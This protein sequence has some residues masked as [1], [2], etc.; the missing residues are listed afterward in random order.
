MERVGKVKGKYRKIIQR[1][2]YENSLSKDRVI[3]L[4]LIPH[5][6]EGDLVIHGIHDILPILTGACDHDILIQEFLIFVTEK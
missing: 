6:R 1:F 3:N 2:H 5:I 4:I